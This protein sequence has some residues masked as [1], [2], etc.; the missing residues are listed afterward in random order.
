MPGIF[1]DGINGGKVVR[2]ATKACLAPANVSNTYCPPVAYTTTCEVT[3]L[4][5]DCTARITPSQINALA[6][7]LLALAVVLDPTGTWN[8]SLVTNIAAAMTT[9]LANFGVS[10]G[11]TVAG[12]GTIDTP[13]AVLPDGVVAAICGDATARAGLAACLRSADAGNA[14]A[15]GTDGLFNVDAFGLVAAI[16]ANDAAGDALAACLRSADAGNALALGTDG[17][18]YAASTGATFT[19]AANAPAIPAPKAGD[20][21]EDTDDGRVYVFD[22]TTWVRLSDAPR[23]T[24]SATAPVAPAPVIGDVWRNT[25]GNV[26]SFFD[27]AAW[28]PI[29]GWQRYTEAATAPT[30]PAPANGDEWWDTTNSQLFKRIAGVWVK[31]HPASGGAVGTPALWT[32]VG[33]VITGVVRGTGGSTN[34]ELLNVAYGTTYPGSAAG[35][36]GVGVEKVYFLKMGSGTGSTP[37]PSFG[38]ST[39]VLAGGTWRFQGPLGSVTDGSTTWRIGL[40]CRTA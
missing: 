6:S 26:F 19:S 15:L 39:S 33:S 38:G 32:G 34:P 11:V 7:E 24:N 28:V 31:V 25:T 3:A 37:L 18:L 12:T 14:L 4:P 27:G 9:R 17:R 40:W 20:W 22:G 21:W 16:C 35:D 13:Y 8:C 29:G 1:P 2:D 30:A 36:T 5:N 23:F 10:D